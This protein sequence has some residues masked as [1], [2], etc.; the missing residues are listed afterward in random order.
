MLKIFYLIIMYRKSNTCIL[1]IQKCIPACI[2][3]K[4]TNYLK[5]PMQMMFLLRR[6]PKTDAVYPTLSNL[7]Y[8]TSEAYKLLIN[9]F[10]IHDWLN[11]LN[12]IWLTTKSGWWKILI[13]M[14]TEKSVS[15]NLHEAWFWN[16]FS[17]ERIEIHF[18]TDFYLLLKKSHPRQYMH[19]NIYKLCIL[20]SIRCAPHPPVNPTQI[21]TV[22][23]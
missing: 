19:T 15:K 3:L 12:R 1:L 16:N 21:T 23:I 18:L 11:S 5:Y 8:F 2:N 20:H 6:P 4:A 13:F 17:R 22:T 10:K 14:Q 7:L 9:S